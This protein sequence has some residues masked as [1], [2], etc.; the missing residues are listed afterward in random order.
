MKI[1]LVSIFC[2]LLSGC[3][4]SIPARMEVDSA[5]IANDIDV[6]RDE[7]KLLGESAVKAATNEDDKKTLS[8]LYKIV[9]DDLAKLHKR[10]GNHHKDIKQYR[11]K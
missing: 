9:D 4:Y 7:V 2:I 3:V 11:D 8:D 6:V 1:V 5:E 10:A